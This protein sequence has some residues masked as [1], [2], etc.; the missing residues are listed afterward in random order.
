MT[1]TYAILKLSARAHREIR[2]KLEQ[3]GYGQAFHEDDV[4][5]M[6]GIAVQPERLDGTI[7]DADTAIEVGTILSARTKEGMVELVV[8]GE[9]A[10]MDTTKAREVLGMLTGG[11]E[12]AVSDGLIYAFLTKR[13]GLSDEAASAALLDFR[14]LRQGSRATVF[15]N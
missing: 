2:A 1:H 5:D 8:N 9:K 6:H 14:E 13:I 10:Q 4:I 12:A 11:I 3:A 7:V 15:T